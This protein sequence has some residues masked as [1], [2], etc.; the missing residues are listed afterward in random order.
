MAEFHSTLVSQTTEYRAYHWG[1][2]KTGWIPLGGLT[3]GTFEKCR[4]AV[5]EHMDKWHDGPFEIRQAVT[6]ETTISL[7]T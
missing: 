2:A 6:T 5:I 1:T 3:R 4:A 7:M